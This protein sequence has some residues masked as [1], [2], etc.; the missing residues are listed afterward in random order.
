VART[1]SARR[2]YLDELLDLPPDDAAAAARVR[3]RA[4]AFGVD[5]A[6]DYRVLVADVG[7]ELEDGDPA[8]DRVARALGRPARSDRDR[9]GTSNPI[10]T[11]RRGR[12]VVLAPGTTASR[13]DV[14]L[15]LRELAGGANW[16]AVVGDPVA[17]VAAVAAA[18]REAIETLAVAARLGRSGRIEVRDLLLERAL[19]TDE[20]LARRA[21]DAELGA[22]LG[23][24][25]NADALLRTLETWLAAGQNVRRAARAL[26]VAPRTV[27]YRLARIA[28]LLETRLE[29]AAVVR[30]AAALELRRVVESD[31]SRAEAPRGATRPAA[32]RP[33]AP[34]GRGPGRRGGGGATTAT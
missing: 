26:D 2:E 25:R 34:R 31:A 15:L 6:Q 1:A 23:A 19:L 29:G 10:A 5:P 17:G 11:T 14:D 28:E 16:R 12:L 27:A 20:D 7:R 9:A 24:P 13:I 21:V 22:L 18:Y 4:G 3:R 8:L 33:R 30:L 32:R